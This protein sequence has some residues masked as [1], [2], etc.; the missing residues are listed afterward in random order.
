MFFPGGQALSH[1]EIHECHRR[2]DRFW[3]QKEA[4][5]AVRKMRLSFAAFSQW[6]IATIN[7]LIQD[8]AGFVQSVAVDNADAF[9]QEI[10][11]SRAL[12]VSQRDDAVRSMAARADE[13]IKHVSTRKLTRSRVNNQPSVSEKSDVSHVSDLHTSTR[14]PSNATDAAVRFHPSDRFDPVLSKFE[15]T[16]DDRKTSVT[17]SPLNP[18]R[19]DDSP[20]VAVDTTLL[21]SLALTADAS[22]SSPGLVAAG[23]KTLDETNMMYM[24]LCSN[25][26]H[27]I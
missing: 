10:D 6:F 19:H 18:L 13:V 16:P 26:Q 7:G 25:L 24:L 14:S 17:T 27:A 3:K 11:A 2:L 4:A 15:G 9:E 21:P 23:R 8:R 1:E 5:W 20:A 12:A 22:S